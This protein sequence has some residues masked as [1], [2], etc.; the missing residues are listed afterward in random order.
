MFNLKYEYL[1]QH[2]EISD[3]EFEIMNLS[4]GN[5]S[6]TLRRQLSDF[7]YEA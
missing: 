7:Q 4:T 1:R 2:E 3:I 5:D 6:V